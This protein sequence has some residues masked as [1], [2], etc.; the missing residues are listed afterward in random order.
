MLDIIL[1][2]NSLSDLDISRYVGRSL[3]ARCLNK[4]PYMRSI[5]KR[6]VGQKNT[7]QNCLNRSTLTRKYFDITSDKE[8]K[9][10][11]ERIAE[12]CNN[13]RT[14]Y[15]ILAKKDSN[16]ERVSILCNIVDSFYAIHFTG[17]TINILT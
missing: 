5:Q 17:I 7:R 8:R 11:R 3:H 6:Y 15:Y 1:N 2:I 10:E 13:R 4:M 16:Q 14:V 9:G 12:Q